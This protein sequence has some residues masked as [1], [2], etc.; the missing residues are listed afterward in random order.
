MLSGLF[1]KKNKM[2]T[3]HLPP[4]CYK[5]CKRILH[6][7]LRVKAVHTPRLGIKALQPERVR[8]GQLGLQYRSVAQ[9]VVRPWQR[10]PNAV[11]ERRQRSQLA[12]RALAPVCSTSPSGVRPQSRQSK[13]D[14]HG[15]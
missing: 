11:R 4:I 2:K 12:P 13:P 10:Q 14:L 5:V 15:T 1:Y 8:V 3:K 7:N 9:A 6:R